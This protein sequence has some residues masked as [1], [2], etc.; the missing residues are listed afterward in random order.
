M[1]VV[2]KHGFKTNKEKPCERGFLGYCQTGQI[3]TVPW[4]WGFWVALNLISYYGCEA[5]SFL[6]YHDY[7]CFGFQ[8]SS[9]P[10]WRIWGIKYIKHNIIV[11]TKIQLFF[12]KKCSLDC[13]KLLV[14]FQSSKRLILT[15]LVIFSLPLQMG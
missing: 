14:N 13:C 12:L 4:G 6:G 1:F 8:G 10:E 3:M 9:R 7:K 15:A 5:T 2:T 11:F